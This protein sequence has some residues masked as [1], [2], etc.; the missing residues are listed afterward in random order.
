MEHKTP[1]TQKKNP[2]VFLSSSNHLTRA[3]P[4]NLP[5]TGGFFLAQAICLES[6][7]LEL[8][9]DRQQRARGLGQLPRRKRPHCYQ[10]PAQPLLPHTP[11]L[12]KPHPWVYLLN[13]NSFYNECV[14]YVPCY[15]NLKF[16]KARMNFSGL[17]VDS[18]KPIKESSKMPMGTCK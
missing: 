16:C 7:T 4:A 11:A 2:A 15:S 3:A 8:N 17:P 10:I 18:W 13:S 14:F 9:P 5:S 6:H 12:H 1:S